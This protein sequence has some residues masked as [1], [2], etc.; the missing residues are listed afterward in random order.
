MCSDILKL[1][2]SWV[3]S[4]P[5][6]PQKHTAPWRAAAEAFALTAELLDQQSDAVL[7]LF[8]DQ[9]RVIAVSLTGTGL[10]G[11]KMDMD[12]LLKAD[13]K[14][15]INFLELDPD[16]DTSPASGM[17]LALFTSTPFDNF[18]KDRLERWRRGIT[19]S[20]RRFLRYEEILDGLDSIDEGLSMVDQNGILLFANQSCYDIT[21]SNPEEMLHYPIYKYTREKPVLMYVLA[22]GKYRIDF[23]YYLTF[24][25]KTIHLI[26]SAYPIYD[27]S[28]AVK[29]AID[30]FRNIRRSRKLADDLA[31]YHAIYSF[32]SIIGE[33]HKLKQVISDAMAFA[34][35]DKSILIQGESGVGKELFAQSIHNFSRRSDA[36]F[37]ALNCAN[38]PSELIDSELFGYEEGAFTGAR[39]QGKQGKFELAKGGTVFLDEIGELPI[40]LQ[41]K[42][43]RVLET[44]E[45]SRI[46]SN[47]KTWVDIRVV[48]ATN[49]DLDRMVLEGRFR[50][51]LLY[52]LRVLYIIVPALRE[53][54]SDI[55]LLAKY[56][57]N[58]ISEDLNLSKKELTP[59]ALEL[60]DYYSWPGN[61]REL[62]N[63]MYRAAY[64]TP[65]DAIDAKTLAQCGVHHNK[66]E[67]VKN[68]AIEE[69]TRNHFINVLKRNS[70][71]KKKTAEQLGISRPTVYRLIK[72]FNVTL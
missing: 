20:I 34:N 9:W 71:N 40:Q 14:E 64:L 27:E 31:G 36:P 47:K 70:G 55:V 41:A 17:V 69:V 13:G 33:D 53:R 58:K 26:N 63:I 22:D 32:D 11:R 43:L 42:L 38:L 2:N 49:Q 51:D 16:H 19:E 52:R 15:S 61:I 44:K 60:L 7:I 4:K 28:G 30:V 46:G 45:I 48:A 29:G 3:I 54:K 39:K 37:V 5:P 67:Q 59:E 56:F 1:M 62:E 65:G 8:D 18:H 68:V 6:A 25:N 35:S 23:E 10:V 66:R 72:K 24:K 50:A 57:L 21:G 12:G